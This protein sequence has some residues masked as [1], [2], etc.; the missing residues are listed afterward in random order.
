M[1]CTP[2]HRTESRARRAISR[3]PTEHGRPHTSVWPPVALPEPR[4]AQHDRRAVPAVAGPPVAPP[5]AAAASRTAGSATGIQP[6][7]ISD[8]EDCASNVGG[9][10][11]DR[12]RSFGHL[13]HAK[14]RRIRPPSVRPARER[15]SLLHLQGHA[16]AFQGTRLRAIWQ[17]WP[18]CVL[19]VPT[20]IKERDHLEGG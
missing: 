6:R 5:V 15:V 4:A 8:H 14:R 12:G 2:R 20:A 7:H 19:E 18:G 17:Y 13:A 16:I 3:H 9:S 10:A 11:C 1:R